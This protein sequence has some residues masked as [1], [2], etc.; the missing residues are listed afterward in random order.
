MSLLFFGLGFRANFLVFIS[1]TRIHNMYE[2]KRKHAYNY[3]LLA[4]KN[5]IW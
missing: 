2:N 3:I 4:V 1:K 5:T